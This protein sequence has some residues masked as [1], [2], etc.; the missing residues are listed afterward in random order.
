M[1]RRRRAWVRGLLLAAAV[2]LAGGFAY[3]NSGERV[4]LHLGL[5]VLFRVP[6]ALLLFGAFLLGMVT[7]F[8]VGL[9]QDVEVR[10]RL[11]QLGIQEER[12]PWEPA[13]PPPADPYPGPDA[14]G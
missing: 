4:S 7:M 8:L 2:V 3:L 5:L 14:R 6:L 1:P 10:R 13:P 12:R 11:R 9:R